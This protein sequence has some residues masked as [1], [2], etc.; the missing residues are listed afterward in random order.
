MVML[1]MCCFSCFVFA[2]AHVLLLAHV[3]IAI[4]VTGLQLRHSVDTREELIVHFVC[5]KY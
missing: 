2:E 5:R 1:G 4:N 3:I